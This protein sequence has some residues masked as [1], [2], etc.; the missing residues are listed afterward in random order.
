MA[1]LCN[2]NSK[3]TYFQ[4]QGISPQLQEAVQ[5]VQAHQLAECAWQWTGGLVM[6]PLCNHETKEILFFK[7][8]G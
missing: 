5:H 8:K 7:T 1:P 2:H 4:D 3:E 6:A